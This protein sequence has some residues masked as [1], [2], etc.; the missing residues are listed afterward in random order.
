MGCPL[1][2]QRQLSGPERRRGGGKSPHNFAW[3]G[4]KAQNTGSPSLQQWLA[5][6]LSK[7]DRTRCRIKA[8]AL[9]PATKTASEGCLALLAPGSPF[10]LGEI[11]ELSGPRHA[12]GGMGFGPEQ[13]GRGGGGLAAT[14]ASPTGPA[15]PPCR[16][17]VLLQ[18]DFPFQGPFGDA[19][20]EGMRELAHSIAHEPGLI[21]K[22]SEHGARCGQESGASC[23]STAQPH[24]PLLVAAAAGLDREPGAGGGGR[25]VPLLRPRFR[26]GLYGHARGEAEGFWR[27]ARQCQGVGSQG[28]GNTDQAGCRAAPQSTSTDPHHLLLQY[29]DVNAALSAIDHAKLQ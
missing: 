22:A 2:A 26:R 1:L 9:L 27:S 18:V 24:L 13:R 17:S 16:M 5:M 10:R 6:R 15:L 11:I 20:T 23:N 25:C 3:G 19:I 8:R 12:S 29:F 28:W 21:W 4:R 14:A 7:L